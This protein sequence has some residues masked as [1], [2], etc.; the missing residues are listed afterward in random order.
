MGFFSGAKKVVKP[1]VNVP[2]WIGY[3]IFRNMTKWLIGL[4]KQ[5]FILRRAQSVET[6]EQAIR[7]L[8]LT[9]AD[10]ADRIRQ[11]E[12]QLS[13]WLIIFL[14]VFSYSIYLAWSGSLRGFIVGLSVALLVSSQAFRCHFWLFQ[15]RNRKLGCSLSEWWNSKV[16]AEKSK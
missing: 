9:E 4:F 5:F 11:F 15:L 8:S 7:R 16:T 10:I 3:D 6:F 2:Q 13:L 1:L 12:Y 14:G